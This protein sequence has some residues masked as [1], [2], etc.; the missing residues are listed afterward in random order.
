MLGRFVKTLIESCDSIVFYGRHFTNKTPT[1]IGIS[2]MEEA[3]VLVEKGMK[4]TGHRDHKSY[5]CYNFVS[6]EIDQNVYQDVIC[7]TT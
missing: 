2:R 7:G 5:G 6:K 4:I 3:A 1:K